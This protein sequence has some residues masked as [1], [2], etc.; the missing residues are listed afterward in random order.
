MY[1]YLMPCLVAILLFSWL[2]G[3][4]ITAKVNPQACGYQCSFLLREEYSKG[5]ES[6]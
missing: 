3:I 6:K 2:L 1:P 4:L 5:I